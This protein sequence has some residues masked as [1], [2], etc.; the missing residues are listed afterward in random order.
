MSRPTMSSESASRSKSTKKEAAAA[1]LPTQPATMV[2]LFDEGSVITLL[3]NTSS[4]PTVKVW[5]ALPLN[6]AVD[7]ANE[8]ASTLPYEE[9]RTALSSHASHF[10]SLYDEYFRE[11]ASI[12]AA[13]ED[14]TFAPKASCTASLSWVPM[15]QVQDSTACKLFLK[16]RDAVLLN[17]RLKI[18]KLLIEGREINNNGRHAALIEYVASAL[19]RYAELL[20]IAAG[21]D[22]R[23]SEHD[24]VAELLLNHHNDIISHYDRLTAPEFVE[25]YKKVNKTGR[26]VE[27]T[28]TVLQ[29]YFGKYPFTTPLAATNVAPNPLTPPEA[30]TAESTITAPPN[31]PTS[32]DRAEASSQSTEPSVSDR[33]EPA[34]LIRT[35]QTKRKQPDRP[36]M[37][38]FSL[39]IDELKKLN[40]PA[41][42]R[43]LNQLRA[44][45]RK[46]SE[47][48][49]ALS[50]ET[51]SVET[52]TSVPAT[53]DKPGAA[54]STTPKGFVSGTT[55]ISSSKSTTATPQ[56]PKALFDSSKKLP[57]SPVRA[58]LN[59]YKDGYVFTRE[60]TEEELA[61]LDLAVLRT[62][63][64]DDAKRIAATNSIRSLK[65]ATAIGRV[66]AQPTMEPDELE[67]PTFPFAPK[68]LVSQSPALSDPIELD[69]NGSV[70]VKAAPAG[71]APTKL[72]P[73]P[74]T[75]VVT[76]LGD[77][78]AV[79]E[80]VENL[81]L[82]FKHCFQDAMAT[83]RQQHK[84][85]E[86]SRQLKKAAEK[87]RLYDSANS[88]AKHLIPG[89]SKATKIQAEVSRKKLKAAS[90]TA[91]RELQSVDNR[92]QNEK[93]KR[94]K[95]EQEL[96]EARA[97]LEKLKQKQEKSLKERGA[98]AKGA[99]QT[100]TA[101][102]PLPDPKD[103]TE[104]STKDAAPTSLARSQH[105]RRPRGNR[106]GKKQQG[107]AAAA[108]QGSTK[109]TQAQRS[110]EQN[111]TANY[112][113]KGTSLLLKR[114]K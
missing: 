109:N 27:D 35:V 75:D 19:Q 13:T 90:L 65:K 24:L 34:T 88:T 10:L 3:S 80:E 53:Q 74:P 69:D 83:Y 33:M 112:V 94:V 50:A 1:A 76:F 39:A 32:I 81:R 78:M 111:S 67:A 54:S 41:A 2:N 91:K 16:K 70:T 96:K 18:G 79:A 100:N 103:P 31:N 7:F 105:R 56:N 8:Y 20:L 107:E 77:E 92:L 6:A 66:E 98:P 71:T 4:A 102:K 95:L 113:R 25:I 61:E 46:E 28:E 64:R 36:P 86:R 45:L 11:A 30:P 22:D 42:H 110:A 59:P 29:R 82:A 23:L 72:P 89:G 73:A 114:N 97:K 84:H 47:E 38:G 108:E 26:P 40:T 57:R 68:L 55:E 14:N 104:G 21:L 37:P 12:K 48:N 58:V 62:E 5:D 106:K 49:Q 51:P 44:N 15:E 85:R 101:G 87:Q 93:C 60:Y 17:S 43:A 9:L 99:T 52:S 63:Q